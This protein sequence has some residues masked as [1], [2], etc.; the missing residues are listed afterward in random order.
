MI[1]E[2]YFSSSGQGTK[3]VLPRQP[4]L[5]DKLIYQSRRDAD[6]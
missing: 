3:I 1:L 6:I 4:E 5:Q 2:R